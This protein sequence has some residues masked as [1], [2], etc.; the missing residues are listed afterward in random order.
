[1]NS[2]DDQPAADSEAAPRS[3]TRPS[4]EPPGPHAHA[5]AH[6]RTSTHWWLIS[7]GTLLAGIGIFLIGVGSVWHAADG[8]HRDGRTGARGHRM[9][10]GMYGFGGM[11]GGG[12]PMM[13]PGG[14]YRGFGSGGPAGP[15]ATTSTDAGTATST[16]SGT[17][18]APA[19]KA[20]SPKK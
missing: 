8:N 20:T 3:S 14:A 6:A 9:P 11:R 5:Y 19:P 10:P 4:P 12:G 16:D 18:T 1:M 7:L 17:A 2:S 15:G 13:R